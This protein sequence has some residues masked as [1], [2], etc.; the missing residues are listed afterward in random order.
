M[1]DKKQ[2]IARIVMTALSAAQIWFIF[3]NSLQTA[4]DSSVRS[5]RLLTWLNRLLCSLRIDIVMTEHFIRK[6]AHFTEYTVLGVLL[7]VTLVL[8]LNKRLKAFS[9][10][11]IAG[12]AVAACDELLQ[13]F[14]DGR[15][16]Q[17]SDVLLDIGGVLCGAA[18]VIGIV[19]LTVRKRK[20]SMDNDKKEGYET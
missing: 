19:S 5:G 18:V 11:L 13:R 1:K 6:A 4:D 17:L 20:K 14:S 16:G 2:L 3:S 9:A 12:A 15:S 10:A 8:Y 7:C